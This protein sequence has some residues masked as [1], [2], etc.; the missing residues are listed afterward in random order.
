LQ[1]LE[2]EVGEGERRSDEENVALARRGTDGERGR[3]LLAT[4]YHLRRERGRGQRLLDGQEEDLLLA[5]E[6][7]ERF[8][9][10][11]LRP[12]RDTTF[13]D[14]EIGDASLVDESAVSQLDPPLE[15]RRPY[16]AIPIS[17][18]VDEHVSPSTPPSLPNSLLSSTSTAHPAHVETP[19]HQSFGLTHTCLICHAKHSIFSFPTRPPSAR[20]L[21]AS[22]VC[23]ECLRHLCLADVELGNWDTVACPQCGV[24]LEREEVVRAVVA[25]GGR[26]VE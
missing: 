17:R 16:S 12:G 13:E 6:L 5:W 11:A 9:R 2:V 10:Q 1:S 14:A 26:L 8:D 25:G 21:H 18:P 20:C 3:S 4:L 15:H 19:Q 22:D 23:T 24:V 7:Q